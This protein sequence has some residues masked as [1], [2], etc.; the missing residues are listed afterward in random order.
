MLCMNE[1]YLAETK[2]INYSDPL[3]REKVSELRENAGSTLDYISMAYEFVRD[4]I[5]HSW[6]AGLTTI[7]RN[8]ADVLRN[9][10][11]ICWTKSC[12]LA[13]LLRANN[14]PSGISYQLLTR[15]DE[16]A[17]DGY[18]I[19]ALNTVYIEE[20]DKW[21]RLDARGNKKNVYAQFALGQER[22]AFPVREELGE[23]DYGNNDPDLDERL[24]KILDNS[25]NIL[26]VTT[27]FSMD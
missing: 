15:A 27:D 17:R 23:A 6:D 20:L 12:L 4:E 1:T 18:I 24:V 11:G 16:D 8:A 14:I 13:A 9:K 10:T 21:I 26:T 3:I 2:T 25:D 7:S 5:S 19:H 22:L